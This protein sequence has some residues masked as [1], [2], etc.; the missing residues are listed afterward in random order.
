M[1]DSL[2]RTASSIDGGPSRIAQRAALE[3]LQPARADQETR[4]LRD[5]FAEKRNLLVSRL[6]RMGMSFARE[7]E[8]TFYGWASLAAL[9][10]PL[11][12]AMTFFRRALEHKVMTVPGEFFDVNP[13]KRRRKPSPYRQWMRFSFGP[14]VDN[15][16][17][18]LDRLERMISDAS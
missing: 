13:A 2:A 16:E 8:S 9:P 15:L 12:D 5:V 10:A 17:M 7:P 6:K 4:A 18:G 1:M 14:P 11:D 3:V